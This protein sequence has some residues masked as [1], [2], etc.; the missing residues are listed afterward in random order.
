MKITS[1]KQIVNYSPQKIFSFISD[2]RNF[3]ALL[4]ADKIENY[5]F[6]EDSCS[7]RIKGMADL[8]LTISA[9]DEP[10]KISFVSTEGKPFPFRMDVIIRDLRDNTSEVY[11]DFDG[12]INPFMKMMVEKP[13]TN[14]FNMLVT[15]LA[16]LSLD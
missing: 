10:S 13:L 8:G 1:E 4:P 5:T 16:E 12:E 9:K 14:F 6:K 11:I 15:K 2:F 3:E 7:F